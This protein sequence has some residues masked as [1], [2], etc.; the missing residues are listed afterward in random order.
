MKKS[1]CL[2][3]MI[4][5][6]FVSFLSAQENDPDWVRK[7]DC[8]LRNGSITIDGFGNEFAWQL[9]PEVGE[10]TWFN[11][12]QDKADCTTVPNRTT[13]KMLW[14]DEY[15]Y[16]LVAVDDR[17]IWSTM[18][19]GDSQCLCLEETIEIF[20]DPD[21][22][23]KNYAEIHINC[24]NTINDLYIPQ[25][26]FTYENGEK[27]DFKDLYIWNVEGMQHAVMNYGTMNDDTDSDRG[28]VFEFALP[29]S[30]FGLV[31]GTANIPPK[32]GDVWRI[33]VNRYER[34]TREKED[35][36]GWAPLERKG[37]HMPER[38]GY[39]TF[40]DEY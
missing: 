21:G 24:L 6:T 17:D 14:D 34:Q 8:R 38:F 1:M 7:Y 40:V 37:Y 25:K 13:A 35:L 30:G 26:N 2:A 12:P 5:L 18:T 10:F 28:S 19:E 33:N 29:W 11:P 9:A 16:L 23:E 39:V 22:D 27:V 32:P 15:L 36:S 4:M 20:L 3:V 31:A